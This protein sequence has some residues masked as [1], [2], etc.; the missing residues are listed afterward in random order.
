MTKSVTKVSMEAPRGGRKWVFVIIGL[1]VVVAVLAV[2]YF[3]NASKPKPP[4]SLREAMA[5]RDEL[6]ALFLTAKTGQRVIAPSDREVFVDKKSGELCW[7]ARM[8]DNEKCPSKTTG[9]EPFL[10]ITSHAGMH[11]KPDGTLGEDEKLTQKAAADVRTFA[12]PACLKIRNLAA[13]T[14]AQRMMYD[15]WVRVYVLPETAKKLEAML[16]GTRR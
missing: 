3:W 8:C 13:E 12:C 15:G 1:G 11:I 5:Q 4:T 6:P 2:I 14:D 10:F 9:P 16:P 7:R